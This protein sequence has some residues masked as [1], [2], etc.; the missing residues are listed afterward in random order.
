MKIVNNWS[1]Y[2]LL[3]TPKTNDK[4]SKELRK[5]Y[6]LPVLTNFLQNK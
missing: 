2:V 6:F 4:I 1:Q 3:F 5:P